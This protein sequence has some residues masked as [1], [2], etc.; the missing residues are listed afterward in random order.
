M[1][2]SE[3]R[4]VLPLLVFAD[5]RRSIGIELVT[6]TSEKNFCPKKLL[7]TVRSNRHFLEVRPGKWGLG[8]NSQFHL[9]GGQ[10]KSGPLAASPAAARHR[11]P[12]QSDTP[13]GRRMSSGRGTVS[14]GAGQEI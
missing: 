7:K 14:G 3:F 11:P 12:R 10:T 6:F 4:L 5:F 2:G 8:N 9:L 13:A 1:L